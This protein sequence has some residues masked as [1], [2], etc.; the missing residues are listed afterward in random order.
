M[1]IAI[2]CYPGC[3]VMNFEVSLIFVI[4]QFFFTW[5][6]S[7]DKN[8][9]ILRRK[10]AFKMKQKAF[11]IIFKGLF[12]EVNNA[13]FLE[14]ENWTSTWRK[15]KLFIPKLLQMQRFQQMQ[16]FQLGVVA[17]TSNPATLEAEFRDGVGLIPG[18]GNCPSIGGWVVWP[19][20][21]QH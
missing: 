17:C 9:N 14:G 6:K 20:V 2:V 13:I 4:K 3:D 15:L 10:R 5:L 11:F 16:K 21:I 1:V 12:N 19:P 8:F 18:G 7:H